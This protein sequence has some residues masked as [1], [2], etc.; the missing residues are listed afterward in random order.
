MRVCFSIILE[1]EREIHFQYVF[2]KNAVARVCVISERF[3]SI[4]IVLLSSPS[5]YGIS[6]VNY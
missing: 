4:P 3:V 5:N 1:E 2:T 6:V